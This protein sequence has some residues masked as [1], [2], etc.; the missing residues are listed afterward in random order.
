M[1][2]QS[3]VGHV[4]GQPVYLASNLVAG[5]VD[6]TIEENGWLGR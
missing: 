1:F 5:K 2:G 4:T 6:A 3:T